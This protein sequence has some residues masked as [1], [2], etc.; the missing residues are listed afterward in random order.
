MKQD[1]NVGP[2]AGGSYFK[3]I[4]VFFCLAF[5]LLFIEWNFYSLKN[6]MIWLNEKETINEK[7][8]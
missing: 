7:N 3:K 1:P 8:Y 5:F 6:T 2:T 4:A